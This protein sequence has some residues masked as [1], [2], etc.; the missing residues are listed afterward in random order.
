MTSI[1]PLPLIIPN[2]CCALG[3]VVTD[4]LHLGAD[5]LSQLSDVSP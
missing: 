2:L 1:T 5:D 4:Q 3:V